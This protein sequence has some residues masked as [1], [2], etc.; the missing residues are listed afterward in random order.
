[1]QTLSIHNDTGYMIKTISLNDMC[2]ISAGK[3]P[4]ID[5]CITV[6]KSVYQ[7]GVGDDFIFSL[8]EKP[9]SALEELKLID[10]KD[11]TPEQIAIYQKEL[12]ADMAIKS[13]ASLDIVVKTVDAEALI[14]KKYISIIADNKKFLVVE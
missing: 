5:N 2:K 10:E 13:N 7:L 9:T 4:I 12:T 8:L 1:M 6:D 14:Y 11:M 3:Y